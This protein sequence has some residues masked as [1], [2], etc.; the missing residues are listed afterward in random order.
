MLVYIID[1]FNVVHKISNL[2]KSTTPHVDLINYI[3]NNK[4]TGSRNNKV[5]IVFDGGVNLQ[6]K[7]VALNFKVLFS[8]EKSGDDLIEL[9]LK[10]IKNKSQVVVVSDDREI[11]DFTKTYGAQS[12]RVLSFIEK[13]TKKVKV[14][15]ITKEIS[16]STQ[17][18]ITEEL[19]KIW[20]KE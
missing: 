15:E 3:R 8:L 4:L 1:G 11:R 2:K 14:E 16:Y 17:R 12:M 10:K 7:A 13:K 5:I 18:E 19:R 9:E 20:L 6:A